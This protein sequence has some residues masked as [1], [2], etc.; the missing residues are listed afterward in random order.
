[1]LLIKPDQS[2][3]EIQDISTLF[4][5]TPYTILYF[6]PKNDTPG[7]TVEAKDFTTHIQAFADLGIQVVGVSKDKAESHCKFIAKY[8]L[9]PFYLSD[10]ELILHKEYGAYGEKNNYGKI[11][12]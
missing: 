7:C 1:M 6:Y 10:P 2:L 3:E 5:Q 8:D 11:V 12:T 4:A 9:A